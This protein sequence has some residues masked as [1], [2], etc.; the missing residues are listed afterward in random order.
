MTPGRIMQGK[1]TVKS[2]CQEWMTTIRT[3]GKVM[4]AIRTNVITDEEMT[5]VFY[6]AAIIAAL[7]AISIIVILVSIWWTHKYK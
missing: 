3:F 1:A 7:L 2:C 4:I 5:A 6:G